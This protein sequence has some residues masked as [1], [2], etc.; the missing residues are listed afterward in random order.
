[1]SRNELKRKSKEK[2]KNQGFN[3]QN[4]LQ[5]F[6]LSFPKLSRTLLSLGCGTWIVVDVGSVESCVCTMSVWCAQL[7][8]DKLNYY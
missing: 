4:L 8:V 1:M 5:S 7:S 3:K 2:R 6:A